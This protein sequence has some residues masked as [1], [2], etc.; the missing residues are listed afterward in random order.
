VAIQKIHE[1]V[2]V[3]FVFD[4]REKRVYPKSVLWKNKHY[5]ITKIGLHHK[6]KEG[7]TLYHVFS[8]TT[9]TCFFRLLFNTDNLHWTLEEVEV[10]E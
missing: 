4:S 10:N 9:Q 5:L 3:S 7:K 1:E 8:V 6:Y 2:S